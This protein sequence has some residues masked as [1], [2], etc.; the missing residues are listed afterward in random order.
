MNIRKI[1][2]VII[3]FTLC[4]CVTGCS[5]SSAWNEIKSEVH[6]T[7]DNADFKQ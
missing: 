2:V 1:L 3:I 6:H 4:M 7:V 5:L